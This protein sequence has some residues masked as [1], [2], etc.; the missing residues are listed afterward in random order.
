MEEKIDEKVLGLLNYFEGQ[1]CKDICLFD[2]QGQK[3]LARYIIVVTKSS[4]AENKK[5]ADNIISDFQIEQ[6]L[7][8]YNK[9][10]WII[11][12]FDDVVVHSFIPAAREKYNLDKLWQNRKVALSK[13]SKKSKK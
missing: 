7:E 4:S 1:K 12:D 6:N 9:G 11:F 13:Q 8:G 10:E 2:L 5:M 3:R